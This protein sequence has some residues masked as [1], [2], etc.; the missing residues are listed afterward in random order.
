MQKVVKK[1]KVFENFDAQK[2]FRSCVKAGAEEQVANEVAAE[3]ER[4]ARDGIPTR[5]IRAI[6]LR[7][8]EAK[9]PEAAEKY[10]S[11]DKHAAQKIVVRCSY[12]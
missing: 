2:V 7:E 8:L 5:L 9:A 4:Q 6:V 3:A 10:S 12:V 1:D 11:F